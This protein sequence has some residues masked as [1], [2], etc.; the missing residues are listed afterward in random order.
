MITKKSLA[1]VV[2]IMEEGLKKFPNFKIVMDKVKLTYGEGSTPPC[3]CHAGFYSACLGH[4]E[5]AHFCKGAEALASDLGFNSIF[6]LEEWAQE[7]SYFWGNFE[8]NSLFDSCIAFGLEDEKAEN[9]KVY[10]IVEHW[11]KVLSRLD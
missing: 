5:R 4:E 6:E 11:K 10:M 9:L 3:G 1:K 8:G 2:K 7:H